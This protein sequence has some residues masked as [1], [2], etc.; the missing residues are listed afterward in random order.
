M[1]EVADEP[2][3]ERVRPKTSLIATGG[4]PLAIIARTFDDAFRIGRDAVLGKW[5][6]K[7]W[8]KEQATLAIMHGAEV[9]LPPMMSL[10]KICIING[11]PSLWGDA[12]P[13]IAIAT[14]QLEDWTEGIRG[15]GE[16]MTAFC[17]VKRRGVKTPK[18]ATFSVADARRAGLWEDQAKIRKQVWENDKRVW[19]DDQDNDSVWY[20][21]PKRMLQ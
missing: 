21:Y 8:S 10:Q 3:P 4:R 12:V 2:A 14:G 9:G 7:G 16:E 5:A 19:K 20:R 13:A 6:P 1:N 11:R 15:E 18:E 17:I